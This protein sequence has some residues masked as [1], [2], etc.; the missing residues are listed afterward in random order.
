MQLRSFSVQGYKNLRRRIDLDLLGRLNVFHGENNT[1]KSNLLEAIGLFFF[2]LSRDA[3]G[4][5]TQPA[6]TISRKALDRAGFPADEI[7][8]WQDRGPIE[9]TGRLERGGRVDLGDSSVYAR[10]FRFRLDPP[11]TK[12]PGEALDCQTDHE[13]DPAHLIPISAQKQ[14]QVRAL[15]LD[16]A[17]Y[18]LASVD[19]RLLYG[20]LGQGERAEPMERREEIPP[21]LAKR[22]FDLK[23]ER[24]PT[25]DQFLAALARFPELL[26]GTPDLVWSR[27][28][29]RARI[30][31]DPPDRKGP[32]I[33]AQLLGAGMQQ[34]IALL[35]QATV[36]GVP[37]LAIE[38]PERGLRYP[39]Q[40]RLRDALLSLLA[41]TPTTEGL[42]QQ[43]FLTSH[44][45]AFEDPADGATF[46]ALTP[47]A[48][49]PRISRRKKADARA[50]VGQPGPAMLEPGDGPQ[51]LCYVTRE[52][53]VQLPTSV[54]HFLRMEEGGGVFFFP[55]KATGY[56][57]MLT[58]PQ[59]LDLLEPAADDTS[60]QPEIDP[61]HHVDDKPSS[62]T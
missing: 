40:L 42:P 20:P 24:S 33:P 12:A 9:L 44:S 2:L 4:S 32:P 5:K 11:R 36:A 21:E 58:Q 25:F 27:I 53:R 62:S 23:Q 52:G 50:L 37:I 45:D 3:A 14:G 48:E 26:P 57:R 19:R 1:G 59:Y 56:V 34:I 22:L 41:P 51:P 7:F 29:D 60:A 35:G 10:E 47:D 8:R 31:F 18:R 28:E 54:R 38:E 13:K 46:F 17:S 55:E 16:R 6:D 39:L 30:V 43:I 49:G 61:T 15:L